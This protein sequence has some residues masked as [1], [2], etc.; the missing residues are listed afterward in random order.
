MDHVK[1]ASTR[2]I[3]DSTRRM[4]IGHFWKKVTKFC[5]ESGKIKS[6]IC[7]FGKMLAKQQHQSRSFFWWWSDQ[8]VD[9]P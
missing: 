5:I 2:N 3:C 6:V 8:E 9:W 4:V 1:P 7:I